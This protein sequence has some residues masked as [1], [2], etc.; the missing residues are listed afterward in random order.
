MS[1]KLNISD[2]SEC[3]S[4]EVL[5]KYIND[6][7][8]I[9]ESAAVEKHILS[10]EICSD[11]IDGLLMLESTEVFINTKDGIN[12]EIDNLIRVSHKKRALNINSIRAIAAV[13]L[14]LVLSGTYFLIDNLLSDDTVEQI[15]L[16][17]NSNSDSAEISPEKPAQENEIADMKIG[18]QQNQK[19]IYF[20]PPI[21]N[22]DS[23]FEVY[24]EESQPSDVDVLKVEEK[25]GD[26]LESTRNIEGIFAW[27]NATPTT[28]SGGSADDRSSN[29][30]IVVE[31]KN[32]VGTGGSIETIS[33]SKV[34]AVSEDF[35]QSSAGLFSG[36]EKAD[37]KLAEREEARN[38]RDE[39]SKAN[40]ESDAP[41]VA[42]KHE[43]GEID[44]ITQVVSYSDATVEALTIVDDN[45]EVDED[46]VEEC[47]SF[48]VVE[49]KP[50]F[51]GGDTALLSFISR[52]IVY[53]DE[54]KDSNIE[55]KVYVQFVIDKNGDV[56]NVSIVKGVCNSLDSEALRVIKM[57]PRW[58]PGKQRGKAVE[59]SYLIPI[60]FKMD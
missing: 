9:E 33:S 19:E 28:A 11:A 27:G 52:N 59:V 25:S 14:I 57:L 46:E 38:K 32:E 43:G 54:A 6:E 10:C 58:T 47:V 60:N 48:A 24:E 39:F 34:N 36:K 42:V 50:T 56:K 51:P 13:A 45:M 2:C 4:E 53:P 21:F 49:Q 44:G 15:N 35:E 41:G 7:L 17:D 3:F 40:K 20:I 5:V 26:E 8:S 37:K 12:T 18:D 31:N 55:G 23:D 1:K 30:A 16:A 29:S 22:P